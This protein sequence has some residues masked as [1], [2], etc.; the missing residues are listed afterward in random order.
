M[1]KTKQ[2]PVV[3]LLLDVWHL[4]MG[5]QQVGPH[6][7]IAMQIAARYGMTKEYKE[8]RRQNLR[9][10]E[11]LEDWDLVKEEERKLFYD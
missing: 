9:P 8:A 7:R 2:T 10:L 6:D 1:K 4:L 3:A 5:G 11:A